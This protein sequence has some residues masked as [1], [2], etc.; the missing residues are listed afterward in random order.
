LV[1]QDQEFKSS[2]GNIRKFFTLA[3]I[4]KKK[5]HIIFL[6]IFFFVDSDLASFNGDL[7]QSEKLF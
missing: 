2:E 6:G 7:S 4:S 1:L 5:C 3:Q